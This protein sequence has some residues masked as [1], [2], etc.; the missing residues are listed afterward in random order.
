M[1][2]WQS[3]ATGPQ[4]P[5]QEKVLSCNKVLER[6]YVAE[7]GI[8]ISHLHLYWQLNQNPQSKYTGMTK[9][10]HLRSR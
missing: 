6:V 8:Y 5:S 4:V 7:G 10:D 1:V 2:W 3:N 9:T